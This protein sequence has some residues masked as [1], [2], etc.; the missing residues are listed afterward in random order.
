[1]STITRIGKRLNMKPPREVVID[2]RIALGT[3]LE[4]ESRPR[5]NNRIEVWR[6]HGDSKA[7]AGGNFSQKEQNYRRRNYRR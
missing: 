2:A 6:V 5:V 3:M 1:M 7:T 4:V